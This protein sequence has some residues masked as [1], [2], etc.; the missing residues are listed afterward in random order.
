MDR[1][2]KLP[3]ALRTTLFVTFDRHLRL[4]HPLVIALKRNDT[5]RGLAYIAPI[6]C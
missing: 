4:N 2:P 1:V 3:A 6:A 5:C